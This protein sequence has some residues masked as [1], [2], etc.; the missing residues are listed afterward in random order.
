M[1]NHPGVVNLIEV[2]ENEL[3][4]L[5]VY[6]SFEGGTLSELIKKYQIPE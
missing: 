3:G 2:F 4:F 5:L 6:D 1:M